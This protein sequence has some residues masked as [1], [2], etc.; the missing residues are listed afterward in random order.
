MS[1]AGSGVA[2]DRVHHRRGLFG[3]D[4]VAAQPPKRDAC[5]LIERDVEIMDRQIL[6]DVKFDIGGDRQRVEDIDTRMSDLTF[7]H[8]LV[9]VWLL[10]Y[11]Y[12]GRAFQVVVNG[13]TGEIAGR[14]PKSVWKILLVVLAGLL[15]VAGIA[16]IAR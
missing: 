8:I 7:K 10:S 15:L 5:E 4:A 12:R 1:L 2:E 14:Y 13:Y 9:P 6:R 3:A 11:D 16:L